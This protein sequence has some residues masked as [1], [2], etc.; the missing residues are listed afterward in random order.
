MGLKGIKSLREHAKGGDPDMHFTE[1]MIV[2]AE[3]IAWESDEI[4]FKAIRKFATENFRKLGEANP[5]SAFSQLFRAGVQVFANG[6]YERTDI[7]YTEYVAELSS[8]KRQEFHAPLYGAAFPTLTEAGDPYSESR[9]TGVDRELVNQKYMGGESFSREMFDDDQTGQI[10]MRMQRLGESARLREELEAAG[11]I[12][13]TALTQ[14]NVTVP[15]TTY[16]RTNFNGTVVGAYATN[17]YGVQGATTFGNRPVTFAQLSVPTLRTALQSLASA[18]DPLGVRIAVRPDRL[19]VSNF[20]EINARTLLN[21]SYYPGVPGAGG[22][23]ASS[24]A[25]G[26]LT[27]SFAENV[28]K[29][30]LNLS[31][32]TFLPFGAWNVGSSKKGLVMQRRDALEVVQEQ[33]NSGAS[34]NTDMIR[35]RSRARWVMDWIDSSFWYQGN[36]G[37]AAIAQ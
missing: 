10:K 2:A 30:M 21:S 6:W 29:G 18:F 20:D 16:Q 33:P 13:N 8:N 35:F 36:D 27:G 12:N 9:I 23:T 14:G 34:F 25:S 5:G 32:N 26:N 22:S 4:S 19:V 3:K 17:F 37:T 31:M 28:L 7:S 11:R 24:A 15:L 1:A